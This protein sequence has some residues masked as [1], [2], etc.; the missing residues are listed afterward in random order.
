MQ[1]YFKKIWCMCTKL[2]LCSVFMS[3]STLFRSSSAVQRCPLSIQKLILV[4]RDGEAQ[5]P[6]LLPLSPRL[7]LRLDLTNE[8]PLHDVRF[9]HC[10]RDWGWAPLPLI[11]QSLNSLIYTLLIYWMHWTP[12]MCTDV[13]SISHDVGI[14]D[15]ATKWAEVSGLERWLSG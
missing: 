15:M 14:D 5:A 2:P 9:G 12:W 13:P 11:N 6:F 10:K 1:R 4:S 8:W 3:R 7:P